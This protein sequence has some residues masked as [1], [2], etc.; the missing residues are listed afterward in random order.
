MRFNNY[1]LKAASENTIEI[2]NGENGLSKIVK[3]KWDNEYTYQLQKTQIKSRF[4]AYEFVEELQ[5]WIDQNFKTCLI[6]KICRYYV[7]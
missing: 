4:N 1:T 6:S 7:G 5:S 2:S 3:M